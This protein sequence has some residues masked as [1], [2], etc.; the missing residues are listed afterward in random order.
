MTFP[1]FMGIAYKY[2]FNSM[3]C[4][5][6]LLHNVQYMKYFLICLITCSFHALYCILYLFNKDEV[7]V[8]KKVCEWGDG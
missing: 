4:Y 3:T 6:S 7:E 8:K 1:N 5:S 2:Y